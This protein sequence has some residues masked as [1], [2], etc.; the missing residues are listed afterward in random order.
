V[1]TQR[2][3]KYWLDLFTGTTW[4]EFRST[5]KANPTVKPV[6]H[7]SSLAAQPR[8]GLRLERSSSRGLRSPLAHPKT[9]ATA[10]QKRSVG[11][12]L[13]TQES[14]GSLLILGLGSR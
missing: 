13:P 12:R 5:A 7:A 14:N 8:C 2:T 3:P 9:M 11:M 4:K 6:D 1:A 10:S